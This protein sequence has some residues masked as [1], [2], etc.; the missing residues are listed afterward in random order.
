[1]YKYFRTFSFSFHILVQLEI[2]LAWFPL[3]S[4]IIGEFSVELLHDKE[5]AEKN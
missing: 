2:A 3:K 1:M 4:E 5:I